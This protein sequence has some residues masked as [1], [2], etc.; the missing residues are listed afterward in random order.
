MI[1]LYFWPTPNGL[2]LKL[3][4][5]EAGLPYRAIPVDIGKG[6]QHRPEFLKISPNNKIPALVDHEPPDGGAPL[7]LFESGAMLLY[8]ADKS[9]KFIPADVRGRADVLQWLFWQVGG[10]GPMGGQ[11]GHF[12]VF[13]PT[14]LPYAIE[15]YTKEV[16]R[17]FSVMNQRLAD[18]EFLAGSYSIAD[19]AC[20]P[21]TV[22]HKQL[23][24]RIEHF[25][26]LKRWLDTIAARPATLR[27]YEGVAIP[28]QRERT[29]ISDEEREHLFGHTGTATSTKSP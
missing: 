28:Y 29:Q 18:R 10:L 2:K 13:A 17:L 1:D 19:M 15:R 3:F 9:R 4:L 23:G 24:Q 12:R 7:S 27:T 6:E 21:W 5:E 11:D 22:P 25:P 8:L 16:N 26:Y 20:Y 14:A